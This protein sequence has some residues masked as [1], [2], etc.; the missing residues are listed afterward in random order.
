M[1]PL[2]AE[3]VHVRMLSLIVEVAAVLHW[4]FQSMYKAGCLTGWVLRTQFSYDAK[5]FGLVTDGSPY[6]IKERALQ[7]FKD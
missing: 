5:H 4:V 6:K 1:S 7:H 3:A 2:Y